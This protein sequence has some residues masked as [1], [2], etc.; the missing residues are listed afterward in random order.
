[1]P[2]QFGLP[3]MAHGMQSPPSPTSVMSVYPRY[4]SAGLYRSDQ[5]EQRLTREAME[6]Y[7]RDR[8]DMV[9]VILHAKVA[10][11]SYGNEKRFFCPPPCIY[12]FGDGWRMRQEQML[13]EGESEQSAQLCAFIGIGNSEQDMQQLDLNNGK[14]Y[15]AAKTLYISD[16]D[17]R[18]HF[19]LSVKMFYGS[20]HDIGVFHS[21]RIK[22]I[23]KPSKKKQS[24]K[25]ADLC[26]AS[27]T[28]VA[29]FNRLRSQTVSTRYLHVENGNFHAS[30]TQWGAFTI[31]LLDDNESE[32]EEFQVRDGYVHYGS[33]VKLVCSV[34]GMAL[35]RLVIRKVDKQMASL[36]ADDPVSQLH[37]CAFYMKDTDHMYLC[38]SQERIIQFQATP[39]PK[40]ANKEMINDGACWTIISTDKAEYQFFEGMGPVRSPVTPVPLVHSLHL[41]GGGDVAML[42]LTGD[43]F[44]PNL[45][46]W[47]GD[48]EAETMYRCQESMLCVVPDISLFRGEWLWV[49]QPTQ[50]PVSLVRNDGI[51]YATGLTFTY[52]PEPGP[53]PHCPPADEIMR[54][55]RAM[56]NQASMSSAI[57]DVPWNTHQPPQ[58]GL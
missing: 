49:R 48:V 31:H 56:H 55:P 36:E 7:L 13:R 14:Q 24:L 16:S 10:Q 26:I 11:K 17:K 34:T 52:T 22:V 33:T 28:R 21:K 30:S 50:V 54:A 6:R 4:G 25:N 57:A 32:S 1:M 23:S 29:L 41:N 19:M 12:L 47:F 43:N 2:H 39:C 40:E 44:T 27:G 58:S 8:S 9:I 51:I 37:K 15:C 20:G 46:V 18:K 5:Q 3:T 35:P 45:Q 42:E 53:R 38:L